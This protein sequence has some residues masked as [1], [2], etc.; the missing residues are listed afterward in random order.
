[1][2]LSESCA[3]QIGNALHIIDTCMTVTRNSHTPTYKIAF[4]WISTE[5]YTC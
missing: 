1:M 3:C 2:M 4:A 5:Y